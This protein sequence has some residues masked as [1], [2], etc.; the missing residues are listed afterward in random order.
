[1]ADQAGRQD[2]LSAAPLG[3]TLAGSSGA[4]LK[5]HQAKAPPGPTD[6]EELGLRRLLEDGMPR[7]LPKGI[8]SR[9]FE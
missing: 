3:Q 5:P 2:G 1:M 4:N 8:S 9:L 6:L 7:G